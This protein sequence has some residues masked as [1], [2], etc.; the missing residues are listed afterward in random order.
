M[1]VSAVGNKC[2]VNKQKVSR[3]KWK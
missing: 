1:V 3:W 2:R